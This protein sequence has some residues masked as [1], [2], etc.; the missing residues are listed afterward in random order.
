MATVAGAALIAVLV[1]SLAILKG[2]LLTGL[3]GI[4][5]PVIS[6]VGV[7]RLAAPDSWWARRRYDPAGRKMARAKMRWERSGRGAAACGCD[8]GRSG[9]S[10]RLAP[11]SPV[12]TTFGRR[13]DPL[14]PGAVPGALLARAVGS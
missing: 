5:I 1:S 14:V 13:C 4:F 11:A 6:L 10:G 2:K 9:Y 8:R 12:T 7:A 3:V